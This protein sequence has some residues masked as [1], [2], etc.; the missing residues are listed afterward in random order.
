MKFDR[1]TV[2]NVRSAMQKDA[3][4]CDLIDV[5]DV[6][7]FL[8]EHIEGSVN[9]PLADLSRRAGAISRNK[10]VYLICKNGKLATDAAKVLRAQGFE[11]VFVMAGGLLAWN[12]QGF[13]LVHGQYRWLYKREG[14]VLAGLAILI[15]TLICCDGRWSAAIIPGA[16][17]AILIVSGFADLIWKGMRPWAADEKKVEQ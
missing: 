11:D 16:F 12:A 4:G 13:P 9:L 7:D 5:R 15:F 3:T 2:N 14:R 6:G 8:E 10:P 1:I 17:A